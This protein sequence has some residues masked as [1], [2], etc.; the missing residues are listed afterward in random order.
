MTTPTLVNTVPIYNKDL[1]TDIKTEIGPKPKA[2]VHS[3][4]FEKI[5]KGEAAGRAPHSPRS[6]SLK[7]GL[8]P[9]ILHAALGWREGGP[10][11][12]TTPSTLLRAG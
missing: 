4:E 10:C 9:G 1:R 2:K 6:V 12:H 5:L 3:V 11:S 8:D 7:R